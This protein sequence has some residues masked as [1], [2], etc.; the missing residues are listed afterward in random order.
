[1]ISWSCKGINMTCRKCSCGVGLFVRTFHT[2]ICLAVPATLLFKKTALQHA[3]LEF[4]DPLY[5]ISYVVLLVFSLIMYFTACLMDPGY[6][7]VTIYKKSGVTRPPKDDSDEDV[8]PETEDHT[9]ML[10]TATGEIDTEKLYRYCDYCE[11]EQPMRSKHCEDCNKCV[12]KYDHHCP[13]LE[14]CVGER[15][16]RF[17]W[18]FLL[19]TSVLIIWTFIITWK[20]FD[21]A[22]GWEGW[23]NN[24]AL[25]FIDTMVLISGG[26][27]VIGLLGFHSYLMVKNMTTWECA[28]RE[29]I[30]Y[31]KYLDEDYNPFD[32]GCFH[33]IYCFLCRAKSRR[34]EV[35]YEKKTEMRKKNSNIV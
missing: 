19:S 14:T 5:G 30:T 11:I 4:A 28:A 23:F 16:H 24:N 25:L 1:M 9:P 20:A 2:L 35:L 18:L 26:F 12:R 3:L 6:V 31:L 34:W 32:Q 15:N 21:H 10:R 29:K 33:N 13:W 22:D 8:D 17:F 27:T 7:P